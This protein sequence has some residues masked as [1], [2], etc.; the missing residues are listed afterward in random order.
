[1][2]KGA[3]ARRLDTSS[4][5]GVP[6]PLKVFRVPPTDHTVKANDV[7]PHRPRSIMGDGKEI[8]YEVSGDTER[9][10]K[11][12]EIFISGG[13]RIFSKRTG[14]P[15]TKTDSVGFIDNAAQSIWESMHVQYGSGDNTVDSTTFYG[16]KSYL[17]ARLTHSSDANNGYKT[18]SILEK[19]T[20]GQMDAV[21]GTECKNEGL[22]KRCKYTE[23]GKI[24]YFR[25]RLDC[26]VF[27]TE[28]YIPSMV[29]MRITLY[30]A[31]AAFCLMAGK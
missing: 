5:F 6:A 16:V 9:L 4:K 11:A 13:I 3:K 30:K 28:K 23:G 19:D 12:S 31:S 21:P 22:V 29:N 14:K 27:N 7:V 17:L 15:I 25:S 2:F 8:Q 1:M 24:V 18:A 10:I 20:A 26:D